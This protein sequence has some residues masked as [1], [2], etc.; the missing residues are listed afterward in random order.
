MSLKRLNVRDAGGEVTEAGSL[1]W[2]PE[3]NKAGDQFESMSYYIPYSYLHPCTSDVT[4]WA[5]AYL[6]MHVQIGIAEFLFF[7][8]GVLRRISHLFCSTYV[9]PSR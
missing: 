5:R 6:S 4:L 3:K 9:S 7:R 2:V 8:T 1:L